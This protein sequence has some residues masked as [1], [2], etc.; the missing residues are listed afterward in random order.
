MTARSNR[1]D[2]AEAIKHALKVL[3]DDNTDLRVAASGLFS[4]LG[5]ESR[6]IAD[7]GRTAQAMLA[8]VES[9]R[10]DLGPINRS[11]VSAERWKGC[12]LLFQLTNDEIPMLGQPSLDAGSQS[13]ARGQ[14]ESFLFLAVDL[15]GD[16]WSRTQLAHISR[17]L[18]K[19]F[20]MP[21]ILLFRYGGLV[22]MAVMD[23]RANKRDGNKDVILNRITVIK[24]V[25]L[26]APHRAHID[27]LSRLAYQSLGDRFRPANFRELYDAWLYQLSIQALN[28]RFYTELAYWYFWAV[29]QVEF[30]KG[31]GED[32]ARRNA[33]AVIRLLTRLIFVWFIKEK[34]LV[35]EALFN[36]DRLKDL[37]TRNPVTHP[38]E[39]NYYLAIL[40]NLFF[41]TLNVEIQIEGKKQRKWAIEG[42]NIKSDRLVH[43]VYRHKDM[44]KDPDSTLELF[45]TIPFLNGG[46]FECLDRELTPRDFKNNPELQDLASKEGNGWVLRIDG[47]SRRK[48]A[49]P[50]VPNKIFFGGEANV[51]LNSEFGTKGKKYNAKGLLDIFEDYVFTVDE[52]TPVE[53]EVAL[54]PELLGKVFENLLASYNEDTAE[55][56]RKKS[57][58]FYTPREVVDYMV[59]EALL[60]YFRRHLGSDA[61]VEVHLRDLL[62][63]GTAGNQ[64]TGAQTVKLIEAIEQLKIHDPA[65]GSG[66]FPMGIL[67]KLVHVLRRLDPENQLWK[68]QN[69]TPLEAQL[70]EARKI[71]DPELR[72]DKVE[73]AEA[74]LVKFDQDFADGK[75]AD[76]TRK[77][78]LIEKVIH[79]SDIQPIAVQIAKLRFFIALIVSQEPNTDPLRNFGITALPNLET[80]IVAADSLTP[81]QWLTQGQLFRN[82]EI[83]RIEAEITAATQ[84]YFAAR[85]T[86]TKRRLR[87][88]M[89]GLRDE[90]SAL[91][92]KENLVDAGS[93]EQLARWNPFD[94]NTYSSFFDPLWMFQLPEGFDIVIGN[95]PY[96]R[97]E[98][99]KHLK[100]HLKELYE[101]FT[102][103]AD[104]YVYFYE[105]AINLLRPEGA[106]AYITSNKWFRANYGERL[107]GW[108]SQH[109]ELVSIIDF[110]DEAVFEAIAYPTIVIAR[111]RNQ[112]LKPPVDGKLRSM[113]DSDTLMAYN[114][115]ASDRMDEFPGLLAGKFFKV[116]QKELVMG[117]WQL[118]PM[119]KRRLL[120]RIKAAGIPLGEYVQ[121][122]FYRGILTGLNEAFVID[123]AKRAELIAA[124]PK[125]K[126]VIKPFLRGR[127]VKRWQVEF[128]D[129]YLIRIESSENKTHPWSGLSDKQA[130]KK[131]AETY[132][133]I[134]DWF[135]GYRDK[136]IARD[137]QGKYFWELRS[138]AY[139]QEFEQ[140]KII[141]PAITDGVNYAPD[142][143]GYFSNDKTSI[144]VSDDWAYL[145][146]ILN[147]SLSW[148]Y[149]QQLFASKQGGFYEFKPMYVSQ[150][151]IPP[152]NLA[153]RTILAN[154]V[155][156]CIRQ[157]DPRV[158][159]LING[160][161][162]ELF[163]PA[164]CRAAGIDV[165][166]ACSAAGIAQNSKNLHA[167]LD[168]SHPVQLMLAKL[169]NLDVVRLIESV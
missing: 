13:L 108:I 135:K 119:E 40:Q 20:P 23:R 9:F 16:K 66:A 25:N 2:V 60:V 28:K 51:D 155:H 160:L 17:E 53:E 161:V 163:F 124:D 50:T 88:K 72:A 169:Q 121:G 58:S 158:E 104:L 105:R 93:A 57:G 86:R 151:P 36:R 56:A 95:P 21:A 14:I 39:S 74:A 45:S 68:A 34:K 150:V 22:S 71:R 29:K 55:T 166:A 132:P 31:G 117:G 138:C 59:D 24:D 3:S 10:P 156:S 76:Y 77:L 4:A 157:V 32:E 116:P 159:Q 96:V 145:L 82:P 143:N 69:R 49:R 35:P 134:F 165:F 19:R 78:Y 131:F 133:A 111:K 46:L 148:W 103:M 125:S 98:S 149:T 43:S 79:G 139:W 147:S 64:L 54:D 8:Q 130:E 30:P 91:L 92:V 114:W 85:T 63:H 73:E 89:E 12:A 107:R 140:P 120:E 152:A 129:Q 44:F 137:D 164:D 112:P 142:L 115:S 94:Q 153:Q 26:T 41:A 75:H 154:L 6:K 81:V 126:E 102:G 11:L 62:G 136:L 110:G 99:I 168:A 118:E 7:L 1:I 113:P 65:C 27:I 18:N 123:G 101:C 47:F 141:V 128:A 15:Q 48:E 109:T 5:Y 87:E 106:F 144:I 167:A 38:D 37:L 61:T 127:D 97:Q 162:Y 80:N 70:A 67:G 90:L 52:N 83:D 84:S 146:S 100:P 42:D 122:R 33:I